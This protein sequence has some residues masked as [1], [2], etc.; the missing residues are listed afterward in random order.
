MLFWANLTLLSVILLVAPESPAAFFD[1]FQCLLPQR[2]LN[3][4]Q[5][6]TLRRLLWRDF[7]TGPS[8]VENFPERKPGLH[9]GSTDISVTSEFWSPSLQVGSDRN[10]SVRLARGRPV[11]VSVILVF[12]LH[13]SIAENSD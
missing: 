10:Q 3:H 12:M 1:L 6:R 7:F 9:R 2:I 8:A 4:A 5:K 13:W 11:L